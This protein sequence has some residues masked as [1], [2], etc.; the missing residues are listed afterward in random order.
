MFCTSVHRGSCRAAS[1]EDSSGETTG[2]GECGCQVLRI[3]GIE[4]V[5]LMERSFDGKPAMS[6]DRCS[7]A[8]TM[9]TFEHQ[10]PVPGSGIERPGGQPTK[11]GANHDRVESRGQA[12]T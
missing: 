5:D 1:A 10:D 4:S 12:Q 9:V 6:I 7:S 8:E 3:I 2:D 11:P